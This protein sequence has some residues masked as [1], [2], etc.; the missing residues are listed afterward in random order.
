[1]ACNVNVRL[2]VT[3][4]AFSE[5]GLDA[6]FQRGQSRSLDEKRIRMYDQSKDFQQY[7]RGA[8]RKEGI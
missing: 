3:S 1:M 4:P 2:I 7:S 6:D 8:L 5:T